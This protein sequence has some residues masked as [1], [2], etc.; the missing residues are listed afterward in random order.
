MVVRRQILGL[1]GR[2]NALLA[3]VDS[4]QSLH[5]LLFDCGEGCLS[6]MS[7]AHAQD[8][9]AVFF[10][11]FHIDHVA[12]FDSLLR[13]NWCRPDGPARAFGPPGS[14][15]V[16]HHRLRGFTWNL[17]AGSPGVWLVTEIGHRELRTS[18]F[19]AS[20]GFATEHRLDG[21]LHTG[22]VYRGNG[23]QVEAC[24]MNHGITSL[25]HLVREADHWNV[26]M[27]ALG[28]L[29][30]PPGP[31]LR[32]VKDVETDPE[33]TIEIAGAEHRIGALRDRLLKRSRGESLA[34]L[35]D[36]FLDTNESED[37]LAAFLQ[38]C[39]TIVC[40]NNYRDE[41]D[42]L[43]RRNFHMTSADVA[44][45]A[46]RVQP[47]KLILFH[48]SDRYSPQQWREQLE[49][50]GGRFHRACLPEEWDIVDSDPC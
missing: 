20:E 7:V 32:A 14:I 47:E 35:T 36:F 4:G 19:V 33:T 17:V 9:E 34:Y 48:L 41:D 28:K 25:A 27:S 2:D 21:R 1:P 12:G 15:D 26:D 18:K 40:E 37:R 43:A 5:R 46:A 44:K 39:R 29:G 16:L 6:Q 38:G 22:V 50:V 45:L 8:L 31:W 24:P 42:E 13:L 11:H 30:L 23:F 49:E 10:S 3:T